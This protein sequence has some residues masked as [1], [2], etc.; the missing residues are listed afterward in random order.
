MMMLPV[1]PYT[2]VGPVTPVK[3]I[4][5]RKIKGVKAPEAEGSASAPVRP[6]HER[7]SPSAQAALDNIKLGG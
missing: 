3:R 4:E 1:G 7:A 6:A 2:P 5:R